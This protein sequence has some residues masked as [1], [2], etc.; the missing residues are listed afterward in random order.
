MNLGDFK[1]A[2]DLFSKF[3]KSRAARAY[4]DECHEALKG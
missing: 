4:M 2:L 1:T 3:P